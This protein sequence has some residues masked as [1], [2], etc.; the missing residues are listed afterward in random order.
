MSREA[1]TLESLLSSSEDSQLRVAFKSLQ[2]SLFSC[3]YHSF[4]AFYERSRFDRSATEVALWGLFKVIYTLQ[5]VSLTYPPALEEW[6]AFKWW[7]Y[8]VSIAR[9]DF[10][11]VELGLCSVF[12]IVALV[13]AAG[14]VM[15]FLCVLAAEQNKAVMW[16][17]R[18]RLGFVISVR[19]VYWM[20]LPAL[21]MTIAAQKYA[22]SSQPTAP[23]YLDADT[24]C[25]RFPAIGLISCL[26]AGLIV[27]WTS[28][29]ALLSYDPFYTR[30][31]ASLSCRAHSKLEAIGVLCHALLVLSH[32]LLQES[33]RDLHLALCAGA[34]FALAIGNFLYL[35]FYTRLG[36]FAAVMEALVL[37][38]TGTA[39]LTAGLLNST[40]SFFIF[41]IVIP[42]PACVICWNF[43][44][45]RERWVLSRYIERFP[46]I[47]SP[48]LAELVIRLLVQQSLS[49]TKTLSE[50]K[51]LQV[52][53]L[54]QR[55]TVK[56]KLSQFAVLSEFLYVYSVQEHEGLARLHL[57]KARHCTYDFESSYNLFRYSSLL[58]D[59]AKQYYEEVD[60][61]RFRGLYDRAKRADE[62]ACLLELDFWTE[63][64][65]Q[66]PVVKSVENMGIRLYD[67]INAA[68]KQSTQM[69]KQYPQNNLAL[70]LYGTFLMEVYNDTEK[71]QELLGRGIYQ[72]EHQT[73]QNR[74]S[75]FDDSNGILLLTGSGDALGCISYI[76]TQ[77]SQILGIPQRLALNMNI[78]NFIPECVIDGKRHNAAL[79]RFLSSCRHSEA[80][81]PVNIFLV[82]HQGMLTEVLLQVKCMALEAD[83]F[84]IAV[85]KA[86][87]FP[88]E[89][90]IYDDMQVIREHTLGFSVSVGFSDAYVSMKGCHLTQAFPEFRAWQEGRE[91]VHRFRLVNTVNEVFVRLLDVKIGG[92]TIQ[93]LQVTADNQES[94]D[95]GA[96][97]CALGDFTEQMAATTRLSEVNQAVLASFKGILRKEK[98]KVKKSVHI[99]F[100]LNPQ[101]FEL[102]ITDF[103]PGKH[104]NGKV[105]D[106]T[107]LKKDEKPAKESDSNPAIS[108]EILDLKD[109]VDLFPLGTGQNPDQPA[110]QMSKF[111]EM[112]SVTGLEGDAKKG[113]A[114]VAS[115]AVSSN[116]SFTSS[117]TAQLLLKTV[118]SAMS[119]FKIAFILTHIVVIAAVISMMLY[120]LF[121]TRKYLTLLDVTDIS[122]QRIVMVDII[123][124]VR[125]LQIGLNDYSSLNEAE[126]RA[127]LGASVAHMEAIVDSLAERLTDW[128]SGRHKEAYTKDSV[129]QW[130]MHDSHLNSAFINLINFLRRVVS[131]ATSL[132]QKSTIKTSDSSF[133]FLYENAFGNPAMQANS[134]VHWFISQEQESLSSAMDV[135]LILSGTTILLLLIFF[136]SVICPTVISVEHANQSV[137]SFFYRLPLDI[138]QEMCFR[139][140]A[141]LENTHGLEPE[142]KEEFEKFKSLEDRDKIK[143]SRKWPAILTRMWAYYVLTLGFFVFFYYEGYLECSHLLRE[144]PMVEALAGERALAV[145]SAYFWVREAVLVNTSESYFTIN[146]VQSHFSPDSEAARLLDWLLITDQQLLKGESSNLS[147]NKA[148]ESLLFSNACANQSAICA[149]TLLPRGLH[150]ALQSYNL[151]IS[152]HFR[153]FTDMQN[154]QI[155]KSLLQSV[156]RNLQS[157]YD[158]EVR[159][160]LQQRLALIIGITILYVVLSAAFYFFL[161]VPM[162]N[163]V[164]RTITHTWELARLIPIDLLERILKSIRSRSDP[165]R[166]KPS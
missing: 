123:D 120:L 22:M 135:I 125:G 160:A 64:S 140:E 91:A 132:L 118:N 63:L 38:W 114:S 57:S 137:W 109:L 111:S 13:L 70:K 66:T 143:C 73:T 14:P 68:R 54:L 136:L 34:G 101:V 18:L 55:F 21:S 107:P 39:Q 159:E 153:T 96:P 87:S 115:S 98:T 133:F 3:F 85:L 30:T 97:E 10:V 149:E 161:Y 27:I 32:F 141:R 25:L 37:G 88:R 134:S 117:R 119:R 100:N 138:V 19:A 151:D 9:I 53:N 59:A 162:A 139:C 122:D 1:D 89:V 15:L 2:R 131:E 82:T 92:T 130:E 16:V 26:F 113:G 40:S 99:C 121:I 23:E 51:H 94:K 49:Q 165:K 65:S 56:F 146:Q 156:S 79:A 80:I 102:G 145:E 148:S 144:K 164:R 8:V 69:L 84:F 104:I 158:S 52:L 67:A 61:V 81:I 41:S 42:P 155:S 116:A 62:A 110:D 128:S 105:K 103:T 152:S 90:A 108:G 17:K 129:M 7:V 157:L 12:F 74:F 95:W 147:A 166:K 48:Y 6:T 47:S 93:I 78:A 35:P 150:S 33:R 43:I 31:S 60:Y 127:N 46:E 112:L 4:K 126:L 28:L 5:L 163:E 36:N 83:P 124:S 71:G 77:A 20:F 58:N 86:A 24:S 45:K 76:N 106:A 154:L 29:H 142:Q 72:A 75:Y 11:F 44:D 50:E